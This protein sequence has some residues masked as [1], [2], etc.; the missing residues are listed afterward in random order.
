MNNTATVGDAGRRLLL[1][2]RSMVKSFPGVQALR[3]V[4]LTLQ[5]GEGNYEF[6]QASRESP[7]GEDTQV[8]VRWG[9]CTKSN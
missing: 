5:G 7:G 1:A 9:R 2:M 8:A 6:Y 3:G 4:D